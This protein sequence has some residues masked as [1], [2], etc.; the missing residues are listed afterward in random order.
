LGYYLP[1]NKSGSLFNYRANYG[2]I[3]AVRTM[4]LLN[5]VLPKIKGDLILGKL[6][7]L[8]LRNGGQGIPFSIETLSKECFTP[9]IQYVNTKLP[10]TTIKNNFG[11]YYY[12][13][14]F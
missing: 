14:R 8:S 4:V 10:N 2:N 11:Q 7:V 6:Q 12:I 3:E 13:S 9:I 1:D 5:Q